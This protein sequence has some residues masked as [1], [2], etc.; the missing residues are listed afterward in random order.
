[1]PTNPEKVDELKRSAEQLAKQALET[2]ELGI[3]LAR[4]QFESSVGHGGASDVQQTLENTAF[5]VEAKAKE[6][7]TL[8]THFMQELNDKWQPRQGQTTEESRPKAEKINIEE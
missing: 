2:A 5:T 7:F 1:M 4:N 3:R 8:A 6:M